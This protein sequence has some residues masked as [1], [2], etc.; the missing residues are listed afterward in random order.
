M[1]CRGSMEL[2]SSFPKLS[3]NNKNVI[4][5]ERLL[6]ICNKSYGCTGLTRFT[7]LLTS[8]L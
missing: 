5:I 1:S 8:L 4:E 6:F 2:V 7:K 3:L